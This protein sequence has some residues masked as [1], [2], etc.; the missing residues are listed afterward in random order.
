MPTV[1]AAASPGCMSHD[2]NQKIAGGRGI[3]RPRRLSEALYD[4]FDLDFLCTYVHICVDRLR[5]FFAVSSRNYGEARYSNSDHP[6][7]L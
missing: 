4:F 5:A 7:P 6:S 3:D 2:N 1:P